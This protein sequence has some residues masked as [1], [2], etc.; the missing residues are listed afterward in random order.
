METLYL[1]EKMLRNQKITN[2]R[3]VCSKEFYHNPVDSNQLLALY[4]NNSDWESI[5]ERLDVF[6]E[7]NLQIPGAVTPLAKV[8]INGLL[9]GFSVKFVKGAFDFIFINEEVDYDNETKLLFLKRI[10]VILQK[11]HANEIVVKDL[12]PSNLLIDINAQ[13]HIIDLFD[14]KIGKLKAN[15]CAMDLCWFYDYDFNYM[16]DI[17]GVDNANMHI[18]LLYLLLSQKDFDR[19]LHKKTREYESIID[20]LELPLEPTKTLKRLKKI[21]EIKNVPPV[22]QTINQII[23]TI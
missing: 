9:K 14:S 22:T 6:A 17:N 1:N 19:C 15:T 12:N 10:D 21:T 4:P 18:N 5:D 3:F 13:P 11:L 20:S 2:K 8:Y 23:K 7:M 16:T